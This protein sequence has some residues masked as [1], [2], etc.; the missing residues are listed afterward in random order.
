MTAIT[1]Q[2]SHSETSAEVLNEYA[3]SINP[4][5]KAWLRELGCSWPEDS[6]E[7][8]WLDKINTFVE[9][10]SVHVTTG[11]SDAERE[12][13]IEARNQFF[14]HL[15]KI[16]LA[17]SYRQDNDNHP[18]VIPVDTF[19]GAQRAL[20]SHGVK[21]VQAINRHPMLLSL[22]SW[23]VVNKINNLE[24]LG[25]EV[26]KVINRLPSL[27]MQ[28]P[29]TLKAKLEDLTDIGL[30]MPRLANLDAKILSFDLEEVRKRVDFLN[31]KGL[32]GVSLI[33]S[34]PSIAGLDTSSVD[35]KISNLKALGLDYKNVIMG[36]AASLTTSPDLLRQ[37][38]RTLRAIG[39]HWGLDQ[40]GVTKLIEDYPTILAY[41]RDRIKTI[42]RIADRTLDQRF[43]V[44]K[45]DLI[46]TGMASLERMV[47]AYLERGNEITEPK[48][49][50]TAS[51]R[52]P[53]A[54]MGKEALRGIIGQHPDDPV[55]KS[56]LKGYGDKAA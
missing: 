37:K 11:F 54:G 47:A 42:A 39:K 2:V 33:N 38:V 23:E 28:N 36:Y 14:S 13:V 45:N 18:L 1:D 34:V 10:G 16:A 21:A 50:R 55:A 17:V 43:P 26:P 53:Y 51:L 32:N 27:L 40:N 35:E 44:T 31:Q 41:K 49:I 3:G 48:H 52:Q 24:A 12:E 4:Q 9:V 6:E 8:A 15:P 19:I 5:D 22:S 30:H 29:G 46:S 7:T 25:L 20:Y 56:Y